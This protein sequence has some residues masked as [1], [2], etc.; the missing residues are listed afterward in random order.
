[1]VREVNAE[2]VRDGLVEQDRR[3]GKV[4]ELLGDG[5]NQLGA[6]FRIF[7]HGLDFVRELGILS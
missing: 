2:A 6:F 5:S 4:P 3:R 7:C 1:M